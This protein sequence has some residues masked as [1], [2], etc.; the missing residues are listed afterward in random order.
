VKVT[1]LDV[2][3]IPNYTARDAARFTRLP[4]STVRYWT[5]GRPGHPP[6]IRARG[7]LSFLNLVEIHML[8]VFRRYHGVP[9]QK[10]RRIITTLAKRYPQQEHPLATR[11]FWLD[12]KSLFTEE[13]GSLVSLSEPGQLAFPEIVERYAKRVEWV[14]SSPRRLFVFTTRPDL[15]SHDDPPKTIV[16]DPAVAFG[17]PVV[18]G[19]RITAAA[20][21]ERFEAGETIE[22]LAAD[23]EVTPQQVEDAIRCGKAHA[24]A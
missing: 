6:V 14:G 9:L 16:I 10:L 24:A 11:R 2:L 8:G 20:L 18:A 12:G 13:L 4:Y 7:L 22:A 19:T 17:Q 5:R 1:K 23:F 21:F 15:E 3:S